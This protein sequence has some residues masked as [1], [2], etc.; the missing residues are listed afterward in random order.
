M[1]AAWAAAKSTVH[2][3]AVSIASP[4]EIVTWSAGVEAGDRVSAS[5]V[6]T[7]LLVTV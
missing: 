5:G 6:R 4:S 3:R 1:P 2:C 7:G